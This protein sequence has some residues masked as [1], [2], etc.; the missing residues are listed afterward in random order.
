MKARP[1]ATFRTTPR[2]ARTNSEPANR[3]HGARYNMCTGQVY[4]QDCFKK[5]PDEEVL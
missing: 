4:T 5:I 2:T 3:R 1:I